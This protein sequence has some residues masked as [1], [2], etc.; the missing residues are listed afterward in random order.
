MLGSYELKNVAFTISSFRS[1]SMNFIP[2]LILRVQALPGI[3]LSNN[4]REYSFIRIAGKAS[5]KVIPSMH[6]SSNEDKRKASFWLI[7]RFERKD[8]N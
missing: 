5:A 8:C 3:N 7:R 4:H 6:K 2:G 1:K